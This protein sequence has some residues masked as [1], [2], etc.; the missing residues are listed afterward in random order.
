MPIKKIRRRREKKRKEKKKNPT[1]TGHKE[2]I[3]SNLLRIS[4]VKFST[5]GALK[6]F[7]KT[8]H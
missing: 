3:F 2:N 4:Y 8:I 5:F 7:E 1:S 6:C